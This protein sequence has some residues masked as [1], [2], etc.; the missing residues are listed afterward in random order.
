MDAAIDFRDPLPASMFTL[1]NPEE[2]STFLRRHPGAAALAR[3]AADRLPDYFP[4]APLVLDV[5]IDPEDAQEPMLFV[6]VRTALDPRT[7]L[8]TLW[9]F[10][11][12]WWLPTQSQTG[13]PVVV[14][15]EPTRDV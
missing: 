14:T 11:R 3:E 8:A 7:A 15:I 5:E 6:V 12:E 10:D 13:L 1:R 9:R 4:G 2:L